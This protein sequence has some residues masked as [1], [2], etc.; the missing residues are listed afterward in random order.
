MFRDVN[1]FRSSTPA[2]GIS[3]RPEAL[4]RI[5]ER[6][7]GRRA[8]IRL[9]RQGQDLAQDMESL[10]WSTRNP[11][12]MVVLVVFVAL[13][14]LL[15]LGWLLIGL[16]RTAVHGVRIR[17]CRAV[18]ADWPWRAAL[19]ASLSAWL[20]HALLDDF[21][22]FWPASVAFWLVAGLALRRRYGSGA[23]HELR[24]P[25]PY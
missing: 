22:R 1:R 16:V 18:K 11:V 7:C 3:S 5:G 15:S 2:R 25:E 23:L 17:A 19:L 21:E 8:S 4:R 10:N 9:P 6:S 14:G 13:L 24:S 20:L 12:A